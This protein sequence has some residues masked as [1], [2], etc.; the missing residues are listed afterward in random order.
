MRFLTSIDQYVGADDL[1][2][3]KE[4]EWIY[5]PLPKNPRY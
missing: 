3:A 4:W 2:V 1:D 5:P